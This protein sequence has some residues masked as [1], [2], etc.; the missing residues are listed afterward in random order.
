MSN[1]Q[2][3]ERVSTVQQG[4]KD[5]NRKPWHIYRMIKLG[6]VPCYYSGNSR[7]LIRLSEVV[8]AMEKASRGG[9]NE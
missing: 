5:I 3:P 9:N 8:A 6:L 4:A 7:K 2:L 1:E